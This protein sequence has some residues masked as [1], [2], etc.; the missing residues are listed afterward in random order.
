MPG[1]VD[2]RDRSG[3]MGWNGIGW[4]GGRDGFDG[5]V[6]DGRD[7]RSIEGSR[8]RGIEGSMHRSMDG[9]LDGWIDR[10]TSLIDGL[11]ST[12]GWNGLPALEGPASTIPLLL[13]I[14]NRHAHRLAEYKRSFGRA[15]V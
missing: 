15:L 12:D 6:M 5:L 13:C 14:G 8:D 2:R 7:D 9:S 4:I 10:H 1:P 11:G 3:G